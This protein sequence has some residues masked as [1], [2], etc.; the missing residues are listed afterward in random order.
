MG[1]FSKKD[2]AEY[3]GPFSKRMRKAKE[4]A[5]NILPKRC[6]I[7]SLAANTSVSQEEKKEKRNKERKEGRGGSARFPDIQSSPVALQGRAAVMP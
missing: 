6:S 1:P 4:N 7:S 5:W 3:V 2:T